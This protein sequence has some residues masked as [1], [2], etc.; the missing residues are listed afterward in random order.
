MFEIK[1]DRDGMPLKQPS[2]QFEEPAPEQEVV[3]TAAPEQDEEQAEPEVESNDESEAEP[4][5][6]QAAAPE[7]VPTETIAQKSFREVRE[8][9][10]KAERERDDYMRRLAELEARQTQKQT[11]PV[12]EDEEFSLG[13]DDLAEGKHLSKVAKNIKKVKRE[14][15]ETRRELQQYR[16]QT[17]EQTVES[18]LKQQY[19]DFD[20][21]L[22]ADNIAIL[23]EAYPELARSIHATD[24]LHTK[25]V[26]AYQL[27]KKFGIY[28]EQ[29]FKSEK[30]IALKNSA[31][32]RPLTSIAPQEGDSPLSRANA[33]A[34][35]LTPELKDQLWREMN[36][37]RKAL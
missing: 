17:S 34:E 13:D 14:L 12:E 3:Q 11:A 30:A 16:K 18:K 32:P 33:F 35:G 28:Q 7:S 22:S 26:S 10:L 15:E 21:V 9:K 6:E 25:A 2:P 36:Q 20:K 24:D 29:P 27:I 19:P 37:T 5:V 1:Y 8:A 31:K 4:E 23:N